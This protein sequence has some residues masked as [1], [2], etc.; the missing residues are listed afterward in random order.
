MGKDFF[1]AISVYFFKV[2]TQQTPECE[3][4]AKYI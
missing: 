1:F 3:F 2:D 4:Y